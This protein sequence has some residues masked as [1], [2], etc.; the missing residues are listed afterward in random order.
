V[1]SKRAPSPDR[2][3]VRPTVG[4][5]HRAQAGH[6]RAAVDVEPLGQHQHVDQAGGGQPGR[7]ARAERRA[8]GGLVEL[9]RRDLDPAV[10]ELDRGGDQRV[11]E[12]LDVGQ[13]AGG[14]AA[15]HPGAREAI[16][17]LGPGRG[18]GEARGGAED[19]GELRAGAWRHA[20]PPTSPPAADLLIDAHGHP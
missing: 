17:Q 19:D 5:Q 10:L 3:P 14:R 7:Q 12:Q 16:G 2:P 20:A 9:H 8:V 18:V 15:D 6:Q 11:L 13:L 4:R 1:R